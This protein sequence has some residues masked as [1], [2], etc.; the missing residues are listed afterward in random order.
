MPPRT[1][2][3][4]RVGLQRHVAALV[5]LALDDAQA[6]AVGV[7]VD[8]GHAQTT[9]L[10]QAQARGVGQH[11]EGSRPEPVVTANSSA[12]SSRKWISSRRCGAM[13]SGMWNAPPRNPSTLPY[14]SR[15]AH[16]YLSQV[17]YLFDRR[18]DLRTVL[19][20]VTKAALELRVARR[21]LHA[22]PHA[23][24]TNVP[25]PTP[26]V[27]HPGRRDFLFRLA[28]LRLCG[29]QSLVHNAV[30]GGRSQQ[31]APLTPC[32][33]HCIRRPLACPSTESPCLVDLDQSAYS[34]IQPWSRFAQHTASTITGQRCLRSPM[35]GLV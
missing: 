1:Q 29:P 33:T 21:D 7:A 20:R 35:A 27:R 31:R 23:S 26:P 14:R 18:F 13:P 3:F 32:F 4:Q 2:Q 11:R 24:A 22:S 12:I 6:H 5:A 10:R 30:R 15:N 17:Q 9:Q 19:E 34:T 25:F 28:E 16:R 8:V